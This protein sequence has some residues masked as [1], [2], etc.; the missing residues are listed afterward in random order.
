M[1]SR[2]QNSMMNVA[3]SLFCQIVTMV[4]NF[5]VRI[6]FVKTLGSDYLGI[7][8]L[9]SSILSILA[10]SELGVGQAIVFSLYKPLSENDQPKIKAL[11]QLYKKTYITIGSFIFCVGLMLIPFLDKLINFDNPLPINYTACYV[12][13]LANTAIPYLF[14]AYRTS[15]ITASQRTYVVK[16]YEILFNLM[17]AVT[18]LVTLVLFQNFYLYISL[19]IVAGVLQNIVTSH[20]AVKFYPLLKSKEKH[21]LDSA[22]K[23]KIYSNIYAMAITRFSTT[24][25]VSSDNISQ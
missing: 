13:F 15:I 18:Q 17:T 23:K 14:F 3:T 20:K 8:G 22:E 6:V 4:C 7:N 16:K 11:M 9:F 1:S 19:P 21:T 24:I 2:T 25:Y 5:V 12:L 10:L